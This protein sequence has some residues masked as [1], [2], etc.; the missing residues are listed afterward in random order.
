MSITLISLYSISLYESQSTPS[1]KGNPAAPISA[2]PTSLRYTSASS[3][4]K[5]NPISRR[6]ICSFYAPKLLHKTSEYPPN[7]PA[8]ENGKRG[9]E[10]APA[11]QISPGI[12]PEGGYDQ[13]EY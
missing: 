9:C 13:G 11:D 12:Q 4:P 1:Q 7:H 8:S 2:G 6:G 10:A 3:N 5:R